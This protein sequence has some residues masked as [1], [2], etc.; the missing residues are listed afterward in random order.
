[1]VAQMIRLGGNL[2]LT[3]LLFPEAF[4]LMVIV[5]VLMAGMALFS[6]LGVN[7][8]IVQNKRGGEAD[9]LNTAWSVQILRGVLMMLAI[10][11]IAYNLPLIVSMNWVS[12]K[13]VY[14][15]PLLPSILAVFALTALI[16]GF[17]STKLALAQRNLQL[18]GIIVIELVSQVAS[19]VVMLI[20]AWLYHDVWA[21]VAG[22]I[23]SSLVQS[24]MSHYYLPGSANKLQWDSDCFKEIFHF[25]KWIFFLSILGFFAV[26]GDRIILGGFLSPSLMGL[27]AIAFLIFSSVLR[28]YDIILNRVVFPAFSETSRESFKKIGQVHSRFQ[29]MADVFL[30]SAAA[31]L[32]LEGNDIIHVLYDERYSASGSMLSVLGL[33]LIGARR[34]VVEQLWLA[35][36]TMRPLFLSHISR[37]VVLFAGIPIGYDLSGLHGALI[38]I[39][40]SFFAGWPVALYYRLKHDLVDWKYEFIGFPFVIFIVIISLLR[41]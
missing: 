17:G 19:L 5:Y 34:G 14:A 37:L 3:R 32:F 20:W 26:N 11:F 38:A 18:K 12:T 1:V 24:V 40:M 35:T 15:D 39:A 16:Q 28:L 2:I 4:G 41:G 33:G 13:T 27:Y 9:F 6:D 21:L 36:A 30:F 10:L 22:A 23:V 29:L 25:G 31:F 7:Q 8:S